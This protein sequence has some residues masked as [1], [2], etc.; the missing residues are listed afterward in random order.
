[1]ATRDCGT[2]SATIVW[3]SHQEDSEYTVT[4]DDEL[5]SLT[6]N[7][8]SNTDNSCSIESLSCDVTYTV[9]VTVADDTCTFTSAPASMDSGR[10]SE[11]VL[12]V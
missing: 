4:I 11:L 6:C 1:M 8:T 3:Q 7:P 12:N 9:T 10:Y 5:G 2:E